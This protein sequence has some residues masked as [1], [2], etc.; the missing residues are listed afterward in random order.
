MTSSIRRSVK[1]MQATS[2]LRTRIER[3]GWS[4]LLGVVLGGTYVFVGLVGSFVTSGVGFAAHSGKYLFFFELNPL[5]NVVHLLIGSVLLFAARRSGSTSR[6]VNALV[7]GLYLAVAVVGTIVVQLDPAPGLAI[8]RSH[9]NILALN[10]AD[11]VLHYLSST[12]LLAVAFLERRRLNRATNEADPTVPL[13][14]APRSRRVDVEADVY[15]AGGL[16]PLSG[17]YRCSCTKFAVAIRAG[18]KLPR[19]PEGTHHT[20]SFVDRQKPRAAQK[21]SAAKETAAA[22]RSPRRQASRAR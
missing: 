22:A 9:F 14:A 11:N 16:A 8:V 4:R 19:C 10:H 5:H 20:Y 12:A 21:K 13:E 17:T 15:H 6:M 1:A 2:D 18:R 7:G 3:L